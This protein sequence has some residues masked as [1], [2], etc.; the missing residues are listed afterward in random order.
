[1]NIR[2]LISFEHDALSV[3]ILAGQNG[4]GKSRYLQALARHYASRGES[5]VVICNTPFDRFKRM[6][7]VKRISASRGRRLPQEV[8]KSAFV[9]ALSSGSSA[10]RALS[11]T[12]DYCGYSP[13]IG[14]KI[15]GLDS[16]QFQFRVAD[17]DSGKHLQIDPD[18]F[19]QMVRAL[20]AATD[21]AH[22]RVA[23]LDFSSGT[24]ESLRHESYAVLM[25][26]E[27]TLRKYGGIKSIEL[28][29]QR[30]GEAIP[31]LEAS[32]G[33]LTL[34]STL[35][36]LSAE[37][38][39]A[40][41]VLIDEPENSLHPQW[42]KEYVTRLADL[43]YYSNPKIFIAT[44]AP[45]IVSGAEADINLQ[46]RVFQAMPDR[47]EPLDRSATSVEG[48]LWN[49]FQTVTP[50]NHFVSQTLSRELSSLASG[51]RTPDEITRT[52]KEMQSAAYDPKQRR[53][54][55]AAL[56]LAQKVATDTS[57]EDTKN[58]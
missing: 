50:Q 37:V 57:P 18:D 27:A 58:A 4:A 6:A 36:Y 20:A 49:V 45:V 43:L 46:L 22:G 42:Q 5:V 26:F 48:T 53:F 40:T 41:T 11:K 33:E 9:S 47:V 1:M 39:E 30:R 15:T 3:T 25:K 44:H 2:P 17:I 52:I 55:D 13:E 28:L 51:Q 7:G 56:R 12:L 8:L 23:W 14:V 35:V 34:I 19:E 10:F 32:S 24:F 29:L 54:F 38:N 31:L 21:T 16:E